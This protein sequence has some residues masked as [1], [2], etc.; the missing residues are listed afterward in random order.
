VVQDI[1]GLNCLDVSALG[2]LFERFID[3]SSS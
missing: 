1:G 3:Q 2:A